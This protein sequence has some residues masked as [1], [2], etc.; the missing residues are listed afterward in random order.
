MRED[1]NPVD[2]VVFPGWG[3]VET[4]TWG[5]VVTFVLLTDNVEIVND[6][7]DE[8]SAVAE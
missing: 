3:H 7:V 1:V 5:G 6:P 4:S 8:S 2:T